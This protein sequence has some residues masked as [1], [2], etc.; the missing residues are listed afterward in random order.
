[1]SEPLSLSI[2]TIEAD[3]SRFSPSLPKSTKTPKSFLEM[4]GFAPNSDR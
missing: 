4:K 2:F 3:G 1:M